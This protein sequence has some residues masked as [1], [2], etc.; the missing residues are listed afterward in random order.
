MTPTPESMSDLSDEDICEAVEQIAEWLADRHYRHTGGPTIFG[1]DILRELLRRFT[2]KPAAGQEVAAA[3]ELAEHDALLHGTG[4]MRVTDSGAEHIPAA[5]VRVIQSSAPQPARAAVPLTGEEIG[6][7]AA[8][9]LWKGAAEAMVE[10]LIADWERE[11]DKN[12]PDIG[13]VEAAGDAL[14]AALATAQARINAV[15]TWHAKACIEGNDAI[16]Y[17]IGSDGRT[18]G[19]DGWD[20]LDEILE[21]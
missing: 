18:D 17:L 4:F 2:A 8:R 13:R 5:Q 12:I 11:I 3:R 20:D 15:T 21:P 1:Q 19:K 6:Y 16:D 9:A 10:D 14:A 7:A